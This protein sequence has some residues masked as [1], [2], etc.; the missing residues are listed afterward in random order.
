LKEKSISNLL[1]INTIIM[2]LVLC[3]P[4]NTFAKDKKSI[5]ILPFETISMEDMSY[6]QTGIIEMLHSRLTWKDKVTVIEQKIVEKRLKE[7]KTQDSNLRIQK[8]AELTDSD[9]IVTGSV[10]RFSDAFSIDTRVYDIKNKKFLTFFEQST[11][12][13]DLIRKMNVISAKIN[14]DVFD[15]ETTGYSNIIK[16]EKEKEEQKKRQNPE[17]MMKNFPADQREE[18]PPFWKFWKYL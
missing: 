7:I 15:R 1:M 4:L 18:K 17:K 11:S 3:Y 10:T 14:K 8:L 12:F 6:V 16:D 13:N 5:A 2:L 9:Y